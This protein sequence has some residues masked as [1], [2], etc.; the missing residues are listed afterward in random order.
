V[1]S[2]NADACGAVTL[3]SHPRGLRRCRWLEAFSSEVD[4]GSR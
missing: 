4:A 3:A 2:V 1:R